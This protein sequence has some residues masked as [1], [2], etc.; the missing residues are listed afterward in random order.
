M[1]TEEPKVH[2]VP[3][4]GV[5]TIMTLEYLDTRNLVEGKV[6]TTL[7]HHTFTCPK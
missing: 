2:N 1:Y 7:I 3:H 5:S 4:A 6:G